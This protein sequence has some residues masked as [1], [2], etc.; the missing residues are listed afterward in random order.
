MSTLRYYQDTILFFILTSLLLGMSFSLF[1]SN[2]SHPLT[3]Q[4]SRADRLGPSAQ[5]DGGIS[6]FR[7]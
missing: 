6:R 1:E 5:E 4:G 7:F 2:L 3:V